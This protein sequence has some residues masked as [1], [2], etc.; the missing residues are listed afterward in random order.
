MSASRAARGCL[1]ILFLSIVL[2]GRSAALGYVWN[3]GNPSALVAYQAGGGVITIASADLLTCQKSELVPDSTPFVYDY[4]TASPGG[5]FCMVKYATQ[6]AV[7]YS[8][9]SPSTVEVNTKAGPVTL[10][11][12]PAPTATPL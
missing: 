2:A 10:A 9:G 5:V 3:L 1:A 11:V 7:Y 12:Q 4:K 6:I 8:P